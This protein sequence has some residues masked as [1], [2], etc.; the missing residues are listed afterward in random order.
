MATKYEEFAV[1][2]LPCE[3]CEARP[4]EGCVT[5]SGNETDPHAKRMEPLEE[6]GSYEDGYEQ[7]KKD[8]NLVGY[9]EYGQP[10]NPL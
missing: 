9:G 7:C 6:L 4:E 8:H 5:E 3:R 10:G 1:K 2:Y